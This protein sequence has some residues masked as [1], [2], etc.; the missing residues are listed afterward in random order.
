MF[1]FDLDFTKAIDAARRVSTFYLVGG[2]VWT[3]S[4]IPEGYVTSQ[5]EDLSCHVLAVGLRFF[6]TLGTPLLSGRNFGSQDER[7]AR[8]S[9]TNAPEPP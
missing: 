6:E 2:G 8:S 9:N 5:G 3:E 7:P 4:V 1:L